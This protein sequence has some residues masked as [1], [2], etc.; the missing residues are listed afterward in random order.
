[1]ES[2]NH[3]IGKELYLPNLTL[4]GFI[5]KVSQSTLPLLSL[6]HLPALPKDVKIPVAS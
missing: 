1:M 4:M 5:F 2:K 3:P 6:S